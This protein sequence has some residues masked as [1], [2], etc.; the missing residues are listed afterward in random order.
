M[1]QRFRWSFG[2]LQAVFKHRGV[3]AREGA[4]GWVALP[5]ICIF[6]ILLPLVSPLID[7]MFAVGTIWYFL[8]KHFHPDS[9]DPAELPQAGAVLLRV[10][11]DR[12]SRVSNCV[13]A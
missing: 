5:N 13:R 4:L 1:R 2:I 9:T 12:L 8:Q 3:F 7:I 11:G 6:Q 10:P